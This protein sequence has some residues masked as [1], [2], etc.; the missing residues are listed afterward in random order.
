METKTILIADDE[1]R[2]RKLVK[3]FLS[4]EGI[5]AL[6]AENGKE[7]LQI[8]E[9]NR[10]ISLVILDVMMPEMD[11]FEVCRELRK[12]SSVP[13]LML[14]AKGEENDELQGFDCGAD[15][16]VSKPFSPRILV[17][18]VLA[19][20]KRQEEKSPEKLTAGGIEVDIPA[21][22]ATIDGKVMDLSYKEFELLVYFMENE[23]VALSRESILSRVWNF[24]YFG[25]TRTID[26]HVKK[27]R[28]KMGEK[29]DMIKTVWSIGYKFEV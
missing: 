5:T 21:H 23:G 19:L 24:D 20:L 27:L 28:S 26:T 17:A 2:I 13:V 4:K 3:D 1:S 11:G 12:S 7:A 14:T 29:S 6:E 15:D 16:Y 8:L 25:D 10:E 22:V 9:K 18:R